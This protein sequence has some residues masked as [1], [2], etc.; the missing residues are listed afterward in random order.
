MPGTF[1]SSADSISPPKPVRLIDYEFASNNE[2]SY[3]LGVLF[4]E[5]F[6]D[7]DLTVSLIEQYAGSARPGM[8]ARVIVNRALADIKWPSWAVVNRKLKHWDFDHTK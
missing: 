5:M 1:L 3:E 2:R 6:F 7:E 8:V 4:A